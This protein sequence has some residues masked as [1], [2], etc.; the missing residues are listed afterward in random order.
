MKN[1]IVGQSGGPTSAINSSLAGVIKKALQSDK[2][3]TVYG[4]VN[5]ID[6]FLREEIS[7][8]DRFSDDNRI[9]LLRQT[10]SSFLGS[11]RKK[12]PDAVD[13]SKIYEDIFAL[14]EK[15]NIGYFVYIGGNDSMDTVCKLSQYAKTHNIDVKIAG[16]PKTI[17]NDLTLTDHAPGYGSAAKFV[18]NSVRQIAMDTRV[19]N[20]KS[21]VVT[22]IMGRNAGWLTAAAALANTPSFSPVDIILLP[23]TVFDKDKF[24]NRVNEVMSEKNS[25][26]IAVSEGIKDK[27]GKYI[28]ETGSQLMND[29]FNHAA[30]GGV[31][32][33][34]EE[35][36][37]SN[38]KIKTRAIEFSTLQRC[39]AQNISKCDYEEAFNAG[40]KATAHILDG[41]TGFMAGFVRA[42]Q[43]PYKC[44]VNFFS[45]SDVAN[46]EKK[47]PDN[48]IGS[49]KMSVTKDFI[50]YALPLISGE[51]DLIYDNGVLDFEIL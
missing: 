49:D 16:V 20:M 29:G 11:C 1:L 18:A 25:T 17:D 3:H 31:G 44:E 43:S 46:F 48:M 26:I 21:I 13:N 8:L 14:F 2:I 41:N 9:R 50:D 6:G 34:I 23:E 39:C 33:I 22:E 28:G 37:K 5:G 51:P 47:V 15:Y 12:L 38:T 32:K 35:I 24:L 10:P 19:Y 7:V 30:L 45:V 4:M 36:I 27:S 40:Y 42:S